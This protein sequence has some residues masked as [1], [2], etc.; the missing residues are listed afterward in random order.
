MSR[1][2]SSNSLFYYVDDF[3][4]PLYLF[5]SKSVSN[6]GESHFQNISILFKCRFSSWGQ[7]P[8]KKCLQSGE[9][10]CFWSLSK[11]IKIISSHARTMDPAFLPKCAM[12][13]KGGWI[14]AIPWS[15]STYCIYLCVRHTSGHWKHSKS[16]SCP[17]TASIPVGRDRR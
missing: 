2:Y 16:N 10:S 11:L 1:F 13:Q 7:T 8:G 4:A 17:C 3:T 14:S 5:F 9:L 6:L 12:F 15:T